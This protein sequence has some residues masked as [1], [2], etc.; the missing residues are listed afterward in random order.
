MCPLL[1]VNNGPETQGIEPLFCWAISAKRY[2]LFNLNAEEI[3]IRKASAHG[4]GHL[5]E[6]YEDASSNIP[7]PQVPF[8][9]I[10]VRGWQHDLWY[11]IVLSG[12]SGKPAVVPI[13]RLGG[14]DRPAV[15]RYSATSP[16]LLRWFTRLNEG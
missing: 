10:G 7:Q 9:D 14:F 3:I 4:L 2:A 16:T 6:P 13:E 8:E 15:S 1:D 12:L 11:L 5:R